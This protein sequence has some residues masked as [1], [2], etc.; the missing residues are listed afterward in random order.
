MRVLVTG[1]GGFV[2]RTL[3]QELLRQ[4]HE[5]LGALRTAE[6]VDEA[7]R[8]SLAGVRWIGFELGSAVSIE[9]A[10]DHAPDAVVHLAAVASG[11]EARRDPLTAWATNAM[12]TCALVYEIE[13]LRPGTRMVYASTGEVYGR[14]YTRPIRESDPAEPCSPYAASKLAAELALQESHRRAGFNGIIARCFQQTGPG[15]RDAFVVPALARRVLA[16]QRDGARTIAAGNLTPVREL[17]DVR[18]V[19]RA[20]TLLLDHGEPGTVYNVASGRG[21][22]LHELLAR[23]AAAAGWEVESVIDPALFRPADLE[24][25]V[26]DGSR[27]AALGW[28]PQFELD[29]TL[30][31]VVGSFTKDAQPV[32]GA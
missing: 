30:A 23:I 13:R 28:T 18:D 22:S 14:G 2:G 27:L 19:A 26:G 24:Y 11:A 17:T 5:V 10:L 32:K 9:A 6:V 8:A 31:D 25:L 1:A 12:G 20:L 4:G 15:Q 7:L 29:Q 16:A 3:C 21:V